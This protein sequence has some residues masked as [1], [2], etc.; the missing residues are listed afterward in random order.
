[1]ANKLNPGDR[2][3]CYD[4][5]GQKC[6]GILHRNEDYPEV[7]EFF[8]RYEDGEELAVLDINSVFKA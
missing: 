4:W 5:T 1:M 7:S 6:F 8:I 3:F 2:V